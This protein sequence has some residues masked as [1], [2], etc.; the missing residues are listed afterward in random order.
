MPDV[1]L[2]PLS[3]GEM[4][5]RTFS[6]YRRNFVL[7]VGI[8]ALPNLLILA[9]GLA[10]AMMLKTPVA[11]TAHVAGRVQ[12]TPSSGLMALG[13]VGIF[14][15]VI[16]YVVAYLFAQGGT[17]YAVS[18]IYLGRTT[19]IRASLAECVANSEACLESRS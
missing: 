10:E 15:A 11:N 2:R 18:E 6:L 14:I 16:V 12:A 3:L 19:S 4:L 13:V 9:L 1:D 8:T 17:V 7:F 5:D